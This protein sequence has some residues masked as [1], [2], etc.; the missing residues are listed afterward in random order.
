MKG[1]LTTEVVERGLGPLQVP[2]QLAEAHVEEGLHSKH[3]LLHQA[4]AA[5]CRVHET[6]CKHTHRLVNRHPSHTQESL[7]E[8]HIP[9][10]SPYS[11]NSS[12]CPIDAIGVLKIRLALRAGF[13]D[14]SDQNSFS[15]SVHSHHYQWQGLCF[16]SH[17]VHSKSICCPEQEL[18][19]ASTAS[20]RLTT[21]TIVLD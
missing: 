3:L 9:Q 15:I 19:P 16:L 21:E 5:G 17:L 6:D 10:H 14:F 8:S 20:Q 11:H 1:A 12:T 2:L 4:A 7:K 13:T 18:L